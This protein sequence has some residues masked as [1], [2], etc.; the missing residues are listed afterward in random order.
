MM[1]FHAT[2]K[3]CCSSPPTTL[4]KQIAEKLVRDGMSGI[5]PGLCR[6]EINA[7]FSP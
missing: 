7:V 5:Y 6:N 4:T 2:G 1:D 3:P